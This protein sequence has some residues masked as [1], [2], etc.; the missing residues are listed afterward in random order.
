MR[1]LVPLSNF[2]DNLEWRVCLKQSPHLTQRDWR[3]SLCFRWTY[4]FN[5]ILFQLQPTSREESGASV[6]TRSWTTHS[7]AIKFTGRDRCGYLTDWSFFCFSF[8][9]R[10]S[11]YFVLNQSTTEHPFLLLPD[12]TLCFALRGFFPLYRQIDECWR[13]IGFP[14]SLASLPNRKHSQGYQFL[15]VFVSFGSFNWSDFE[16][17]FNWSDFE[18]R[19]S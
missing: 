9:I 14:P 18:S 5:F 12:F 2:L 1:K 4:D 3:S 15:K 6:C 11:D 13:P 17:S 8:I 16:S 19:C 10:A 7:G